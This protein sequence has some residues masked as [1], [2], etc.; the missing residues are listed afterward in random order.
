MKIKTLLGF[1]LSE[2][3]ITLGIIGVVAV[4]TIPVLMTKFAKSRTETQLKTFYSKINQTVKMSVAENGDPEG[5]ITP[6]KVYNYEE[7]VEFLKTY[8]LPYMKTLGYEECLNNN[9][10]FGVCIYLLDGGLM[11]FSIDENGGDISYW[12]DINKAL[13][14]YKN[15]NKNIPNITRYFF[16]FQFAK[17]TNSEKSKEL[18]STQYVEPYIYGWNGTREG[19]KST[20]YGCAKSASGSYCTKLIQMSDWKIPKDYPW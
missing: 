6:N 17:F 2:V 14:K 10:Q 4:M 18:K 3:L 8:F 12:T 5:W 11:W 7:N 20:I 13:D 19:L 15:N 16:R 1:T 9:K